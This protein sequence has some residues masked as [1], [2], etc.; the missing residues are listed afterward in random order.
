MVNFQNEILVS[1]PQ[2]ELPLHTT[3]QSDYVVMY[4][5]EQGA[6]RLR[7]DDKEMVAASSAYLMLLP[8]HKAVVTELTPDF[9]MRYMQISAGFFNRF[10]FED[11]F[12]IHQQVLRRP[13]LALSEQ[14]FGAVNMCFD[15]IRATILQTDNPNR[16]KT[17][18][19]ISMAYFYALGHY[20]YPREEDGGSD[21]EEEV[22]QRFMEHV[23]F[24]FREHHDVAFYADMLH[25]TP[26]Y[27]GACVKQTTRLT[28]KHVID[29]QIIRYAKDR[30][31]QTTLSV[32]EIAY[33]LQFPDQS[34]FGKFFRLHTGLSPKDWR[35]Q[36]GG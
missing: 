7:I 24:H 10:Q 15:M 13:Y 12:N 3:L 35:Q 16:E 26:K 5:I 2:T 36:Y 18:Y 9:R 32:S 23:R 20:F 30:L 28:A 31:K 11:S 17:I 33:E 21:R 6:M 14:I 22:A 27:L 19:H 8:E 29:D 4:L 1:D 25:I 34:S